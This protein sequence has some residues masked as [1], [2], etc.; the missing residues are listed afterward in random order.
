MDHASR[1]G[2]ALADIYDLP[3][4]TFADYADFSKNDNKVSPP[5]DTLASFRAISSYCYRYMKISTST[6]L[7]NFLLVSNSRVL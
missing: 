1:Y 3:Y 4:V 2:P 7:Y 6:C 5:V